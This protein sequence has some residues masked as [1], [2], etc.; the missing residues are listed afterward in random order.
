MN[1][2]PSSLHT[3]FRRSAYQCVRQTQRSNRIPLHHVQRQQ[4]HRCLSANA[5][6]SAPR[7]TVDPSRRATGRSP[8]DSAQRHKRT[9]ALCAAGIVASGLGMYVIIGTADLDTNDKKKKP[10]SSDKPYTGPGSVVKLDGP[11]GMEMDPKVTVIDG[12]EQVPTGNSTIPFFPKTIKLPKN[13]GSEATGRQAGDE[14]PSSSQTEQYTLIG[15]GIRTVSFLS[16]QVYVVGLYIATSDIAAIQQ[17]LVRRAATPTSAS[18]VNESAVA[19]TSLVP[20]ERE[21]LKK[22]LLDPEKGEEIW[23]QVLRDSGIRTA[24]RI[25][26]TRNTDFLHLR[27]G[28]VRAITARAQSANARAKELAAK[29]GSS[30]PAGAVVESEFAD[31]SF[32]NAVSDFK[33]LFGGGVRKNVPKGHILYLLRDRMGGL[34]TMFQAGDRKLLVWLGEVRDERLSRLLWMGYLAGKKVASEG[35]RK[36]V[37][38]GVMEIVERPIGTV[39]QRVG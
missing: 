9:M 24:L 10:P 17:R 35:A 2:P 25:V 16:I 27:D 31:D 30:I 4:Q 21:E 14:I 39:E 13:D 7:F 18:A 12:V 36:S 34:E 20:G 5:P 15:Q 8:A 26:P 1:I 28:W 37:V 3:P 33:T 11:A 19:A 23:N 6:G 32:G 38:D 22:M 29:Q